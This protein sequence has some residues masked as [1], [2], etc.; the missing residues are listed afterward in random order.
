VGRHG[1]SLDIFFRAER[2]AA[3]TLPFSRNGGAAE[4]GTERNEKGSLEMYW[5]PHSRQMME[6]ASI[7]WN[8]LEK[9]ESCGIPVSLGGTRAAMGRGVS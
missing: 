1:W 7:P 6:L 5:A 2:T 3:E 9:A 8:T 4:I